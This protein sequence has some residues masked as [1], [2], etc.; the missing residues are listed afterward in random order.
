METN[1]TV[2]TPVPQPGLLLTAEAQSYLREAGKWANFLGILGFVFCGLILIAAFSMA[3]IFAK[4]AEI[5]PSPMATTLAGIGGGA[6]TVVYILI[7]L[8]YFFFSLYLYQFGSKIKK[9][10]VFSDVAQVTRA[11]GKLKS[12]FKLWGILTIV[13]LC[14]YALMIIVFIAIGIGTASMMHH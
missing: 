3:G 9:G 8:I 14:L 1:E 12:F 7:D 6:I 10:I 13:V 4:I 11:L 2:V 5:S